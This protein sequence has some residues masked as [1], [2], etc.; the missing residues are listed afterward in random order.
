MRYRHEMADED[1]A[2]DRLVQK[3]FLRANTAQGQAHADLVAVATTVQALVD[4]LVEK[5]VVGA[6]ELEAQLGAAGRRLADSDLSR[7][8]MVRTADV[9][10][11]KYAEPNAEVDCGARM[12][13]C[14]GACCACE[15]PLAVQDLEE[16][17]VKW[18][19]ARPYYIRHA[20]DGRCVHQVRATGFCGTYEKRPLA[21]RS[22]TCKNDRRIWKDFDAMIPN[23]K[24]I[25]ALL[26]HKAERPITIRHRTA[27][28]KVVPGPEP[29]P[30]E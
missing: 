20:D 21:C 23:E 17:A 12:H 6:A 24:A 22:Y 11:D 28:P 3:A 13:L 16:G 18:D 30:E 27:V 14:H 7:R 5:G 10:R 15:V 9:L 19:L 29:E 25:A 4:L 26:V 2:L 8:N 1:D